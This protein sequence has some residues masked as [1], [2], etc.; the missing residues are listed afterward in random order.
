MIQYDIIKYNITKAKLE[1]EIAHWVCRRGEAA[2]SKRTLSEESQRIHLSP[3][4]VSGDSDSWY[5]PGE[6]IKDSA[7]RAS[8]R[9]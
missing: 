4:A 3:P 6:F 8:T 7:P 9:S 1:Q 2:T 5:P